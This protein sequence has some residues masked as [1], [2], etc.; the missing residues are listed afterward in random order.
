MH[1]DKKITKVFTLL[2]SLVVKLSKMRW[3]KTSDIVPTLGMSWR[4]TTLVSV[5]YAVGP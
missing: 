2:P 4:I 3:G 1:R 5:K